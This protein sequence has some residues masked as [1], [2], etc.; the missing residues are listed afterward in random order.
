MKETIVY[1]SK[2]NNL[3]SYNVATKVKRAVSFSVPT[4][5]AEST[6]TNRIAKITLTNR[7]AF[8]MFDYE[9]EELGT[10]S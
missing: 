1:R 8:P 2:E 9:R 7:M 5:P 10:A 3:A 4:I 6:E